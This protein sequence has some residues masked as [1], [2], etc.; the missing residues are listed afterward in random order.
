MEAQSASVENS[1]DL[2]VLPAF[3]G[4]ECAMGLMS[5][6]EQLAVRVRGAEALA[7]LKAERGEAALRSSGAFLRVWVGAWAWRWEWACGCRAVDV[8]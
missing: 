8:A 7:Q 4:L 2:D 6:M 3:L 5:S 1:A